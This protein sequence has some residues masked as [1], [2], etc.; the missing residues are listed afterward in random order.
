M[1][2]EEREEFDAMK[3]RIEA[4]ELVNDGLNNRGQL[5]PNI[6]YTLNL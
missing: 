3:E 1:T 6:D 5:D 2:P 4:L